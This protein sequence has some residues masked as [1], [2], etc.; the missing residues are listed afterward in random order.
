MLVTS[1]HAP[2]VLMY[3]T[4][5]RALNELS[6]STKH[7][8]FGFLGDEEYSTM[9]IWPCELWPCLEFHASPSG[10]LLGGFE[11]GDTCG[12]VVEED[13]DGS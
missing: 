4:S 2:V 8:P 7:E 9:R 1:C 10:L 5:K 3:V 13:G 12:V 6:L 11:V